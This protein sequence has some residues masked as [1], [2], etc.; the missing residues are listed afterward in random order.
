MISSEVYQYAEYYDIAASFVDVPRQIDLLEAYIRAHSAIPVRRVLDICCGP[1]PQLREFV[2]RGYQGIG[3]DA[4]RPMLDYLH[5]K[6]AEEQRPVETACADLRD[7]TL[8][9]PVDFGYI[10]MGTIPYVGSRQGMLSHLGCVAQALRPGGLYL[11]ENLL[12]DWVSASTGA[13]ADWTMARDGITVTSHFQLDVLDPL[14]QT[15][16]HILTFTVDDNG[17]EVHLAEDCVVPLIFPQEFIGLVDGQGAFEF[18]GFFE[19]DSIAPLRRLANDNIALL[20]RR[21]S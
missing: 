4:S 20:R 18:I 14:A 9:E 10:L 19:R 13:S 16:R 2:R 1:S 7:F 11:I 3:L 17:K 15:A 21:S 6:A 8:A 5:R 12:M